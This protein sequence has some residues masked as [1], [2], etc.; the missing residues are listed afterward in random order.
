MTTEPR[1]PG[2]P[3]YHI[4]DVRETVTGQLIRLHVSED[5]RVKESVIELEDNKHMTL[6]IAID[7][8][9]MV[10]GKQ[11]PPSLAPVPSPWVTDVEARTID[12]A[13]TDGVGTKHLLIPGH[14]DYER[15]LTRRVAREATIKALTWARDS[16]LAQSDLTADTQWIVRKVLA[17]AIKAIDAELANGGAGSGEGKGDE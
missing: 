9:S 5:W 10:K 14:G 6:E 3:Q 4:L 12:L 13:L 7:G 2:T 1:S 16:M 15:E 8:V 17:T 11:P